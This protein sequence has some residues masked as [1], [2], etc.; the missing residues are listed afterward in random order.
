MAELPAAIGTDVSTFVLAF[1][2]TTGQFDT[3][4]IST[5]VRDNV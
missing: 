2:D 1:Q 3:T 5:T 4:G